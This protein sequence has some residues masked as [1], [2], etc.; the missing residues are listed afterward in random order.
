MSP[1]LTI[2]IPTYNRPGLLVRAVESALIACPQDGEVIVVDDRSDT[3]ETAL[4]QLAQDTRLQI[5]TNTGDKGAAG[6]RN[7]GISIANGDIILFLD[8]DDALVAD[9][10]VRIQNAAARST[11]AFGFSAIDV[12]AGETR[13]RVSRPA[14]EHGLIGADVPLEQKTAAFSAGFW[15][16]K[17]TF[18][19]VGPIAP[20][21]TNDED[22]DL[23]CRFYGQGHQAWFEPEPGCIIYRDYETGDTTAPQL[24]RSTAPAEM[25]ACYMRTFQRNE[26]YFGRVSADRWFL[27]RRALRAA[28]KTRTD[29]VART[30]LKGLRP[31]S[32]QIK[33]WLYWQMKRAGPR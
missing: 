22:T 8:D 19:S 12:V 25:A 16:R 24:T 14:L 21:Q 29:A 7:M 6:A 32:W 28:G 11:A 15:I 2:V 3:A 9:Y 5:V 31:V 27:L 1:T 26:G 10:P 17:S 18:Q 23:C 33:G 4:A 13:Q 30:L 20:D